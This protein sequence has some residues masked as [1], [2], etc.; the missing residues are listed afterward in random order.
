[1]D[2][3]AEVVE[4][5]VWHVGG[6]LGVLIALLG[7]YDFNFFWFLLTER[8]VSLYTSIVNGSL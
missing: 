3:R 7:W 5:L 6:R 2:Q 1:M 8:G 4:N